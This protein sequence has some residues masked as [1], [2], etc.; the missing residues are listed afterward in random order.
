[1]DS[2]SGNDIMQETKKFL[3]RYQDAEREI[4]AK[5]DQIHRLRELATSTTQALGGDRVQSSG[6]NKLEKI[7]AKIGDMETEVDAEV[8]GLAKI[9]ADVAG[10]ISRVPDAAQRNVLILRYINGMRWE[11]IAVEMSYTYRHIIR[12]HGEALLAVKDVLL[13]PKNL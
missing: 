1:M 10:V 9:K 7:V 2:K 8:D 3:R 5:L 4:K 11:E 6:E 12:L 13:C